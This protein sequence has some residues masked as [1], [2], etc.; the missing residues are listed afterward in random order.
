MNI[1]SIGIAGFILGL[2]FKFLHWP[3]ANIILLSS[4]IVTIV[5][6]TVLLARKPGP[7]TLHVQRPAMLFGS[8]SVALMGTLFKMMHWPGANIML[9][10]GLMTCAAWFLTSS[11][12]TAGMAQR[13]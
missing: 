8:I 9:L 7:W 12:R 11:Y 10:I 6:L 13:S 1:R 5:M 3:G 4:A 2:L